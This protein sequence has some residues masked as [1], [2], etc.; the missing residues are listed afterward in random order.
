MGY[1]TL[2]KCVIAREAVLPVHRPR[3]TVQ[4][5][6]RLGADPE[7]CGGSHSLPVLAPALREVVCSSS[8]EFIPIYGP[9]CLRGEETLALAEGSCTS[10]QFCPPAFLALTYVTV[11]ALQRPVAS[12]E[13]ALQAPMACCYALHH[14]RMPLTLWPLII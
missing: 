7:P 8:I 9:R 12:F 1:Y 10:L 4:I 2:R 14:F 6:S 13:A 11:D 3:H 5:A